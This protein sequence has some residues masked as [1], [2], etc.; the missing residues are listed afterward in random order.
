MPVRRDLSFLILSLNKEQNP[1]LCLA[2]SPE[3]NSLTGVVYISNN[4]QLS[5]RGKYFVPLV[6]INL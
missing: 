3:D 6:S 1:D 4:M 2:I 5:F